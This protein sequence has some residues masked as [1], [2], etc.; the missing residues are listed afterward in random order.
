MVWKARRDKTCHPEPVE[1]RFGRSMNSRLTT[2]KPVTLSLSKGSQNTAGFTMLGILALMIMLSIMG[3]MLAP[4]LIQRIQRDE[5]VVEV[6]NLKILASGLESYIFQNRIIP[7]S[8]IGDGANGNL[9]DDNIGLMAGMS[10]GEVG[11]NYRKCGRLYWFDPATNLPD[12]PTGGSYDQDNDTVPICSLPACDSNIPAQLAAAAPRNTRAMIISDVSEGCLEGL[13]SV[14]RTSGGGFDN[15]WNADNAFLQDDETLKIIRLNFGQIFEPVTLNSRTVSQYGKKSYMNVWSND[16]SPIIVFPSQV[17]VT[18]LIVKG[19][20]TLPQNIPDYS[21]AVG[22]F[23]GDGTF[24]AV[25]FSGPAPAV[26]FIY[27]STTVPSVGNIPQDDVLRIWVRVG[28]NGGSPS[29]HVEVVV[30]YDAGAVTVF[31]NGS[32]YQLGNAA[33]GTI[34]GGTTI[35]VWVING[36]PIR[37]FSDNAG[38]TQIMAT[39]IKD[40]ETFDFT[41]GPPPLWSR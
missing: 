30:N 40:S 38:V 28:P 13:G 8:G 18:N 36:T 7:A 19:M 15:A 20:L 35:T 31:N 21:L 39:V 17:R 29:G 37:M 14:D 5:A 27:D 22:T 1:G 24:L 3:A 41:P 33:L 26:E 11:E 10:P 4:G 12:L 23:S 32:S 16:D 6:E 9:W 25:N 34:D 2:T